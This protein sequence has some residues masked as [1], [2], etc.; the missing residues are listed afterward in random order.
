MSSTVASTVCADQALGPAGKGKDFKGPILD[1]TEQS[2]RVSETLV[3][4]AGWGGVRRG[5]GGQELDLVYFP[6]SCHD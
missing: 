1:I 4:G 5:G 6:K 2:E 3:A